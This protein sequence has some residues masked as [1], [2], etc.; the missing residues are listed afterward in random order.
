MIYNPLEEYISKFK[1]L[2]LVNTNSFFD[3]LVLKS[4]V[5]IGKTG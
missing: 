2:H 1:E 4:G 3:E 5:S